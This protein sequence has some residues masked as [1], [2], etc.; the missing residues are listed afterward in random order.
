MARCT[1][2]DP[3]RSVEGL[4]GGMES[5]F[6]VA[7]AQCFSRV[8]KVEENLAVTAEMCARAHEAGADLVLFP[9]CQITGYSYRNLGELVRRTAEP[10][11]GCLGQFLVNLARKNSLVICTGMLE[12]EG[13]ASYN[14]HV[15]AF[16]DGRLEKQRKGCSSP[17]EE[18]V[19]CFETRRNVFCW[20]GVRFGIMVCADNAL[21]D[22]EEQFKRLG[23]SLL[24]HPSAGRVGDF[25]FP[26]E[27]ELERESRETIRQA[28][29]LAE[30]L[31]VCY[32]V[33]NPTGFSGEDHYPGN[34]WIV[35]PTEGV[36]V[37]LPAAVSPVVTLGI[38]TMRPAGFS[39]RVPVA[40]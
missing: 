22:H 3:C 29:C 39:G 21:P 36:L 7:V 10:V 32:A 34:S 28:C 14:T 18:Y 31:N 13:D 4:T 1:D 11:D 9:E 17:N 20:K 27:E 30:R 37:H 6:V 35:D 12:R 25:P 23:I 16:P 15:V 19:L 2:E 8:G 5:G 40:D 26:S 33:A 24:L 38:G